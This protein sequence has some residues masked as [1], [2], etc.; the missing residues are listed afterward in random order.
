MNADPI[1]RCYRWLEYLAFG[2][3]L[4]RRRFAFL[5]ELVDARRIMIL[6]EGDGRL[7][8][9]LLPIASQAS[10]DVVELSAEMIALARAGAGS[11]VRFLQH[12]ARSI[13]FESYDAIVTCFFLDCFN[14][15]DSGLL[16]ERLASALKPGG[17]WLMSDFAV[18]ERGWQRWHACVWV[19]TMYLFFRITTGLT[20]R[21]LPPI[22]DQLRNAGLTRI[23]RKAERAGMIV[24]ELWRSDG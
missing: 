14:E 6:G 15:E 7:L 19:W 17:L 18:P 4:E 20:T 13:A 21:W 24:S 23:A 10:I 5:G 8:A 16:V 11:R 3:A 2:R 12:D 9:R 1:A 22:E